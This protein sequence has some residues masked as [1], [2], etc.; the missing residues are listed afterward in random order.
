MSK[1]V[2]HFMNI[3]AKQALFGLLHQSF[4]Q[5]EI[6]LCYPL[7][8]LG[9][10]KYIWKPE[11]IIRHNSKRI[12]VELVALVRTQRCYSK[13]LYRQCSHMFFNPILSNV[14]ETFPILK[15]RELGYF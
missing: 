5:V 11:W 6:Y 2:K 10:N 13:N 9:V 7:E 14:P 4:E 1:L 12:T 8:N 15:G 3:L